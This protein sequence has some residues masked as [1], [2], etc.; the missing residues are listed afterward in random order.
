MNYSEQLKDPRWQKK[1]LEILQR[2]D[3]TCQ[4]CGDKESTLHVHHKCYTKG[5]KPW[6]YEAYS[7]ITLCEEC[8]K[9]EKETGFDEE[10]NQITTQR[11]AL[12]GILDGM[13]LQHEKLDL[14]STF[15]N[16]RNK[17]NPRYLIDMLHYL[18]T[19]EKLLSQLEKEFE[20]NMQPSTKKVLRRRCVLN[21]QR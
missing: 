18:F 21:K 7:L 6:E 9:D 17:Y 14:A 4:V 12:I 15:Y 11:E 5:K 8:H 2:D 16:I 13:F 3:F 19:N 10:G 20:K 1:R